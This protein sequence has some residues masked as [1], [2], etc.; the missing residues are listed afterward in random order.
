[1]AYSQ[2]TVLLGGLVHVPIIVAILRAWDEKSK[3][4]YLATQAI[5]EAAAQ[6][7]KAEAEAKALAEA[8]AAKKAK[9]KALAEAKAAAK[10]EEEK[11]VG[12]NAEQT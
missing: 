1:M 10:A 4:R 12:D 7:L 9:E 11:K 3:A 8:K 6:K 2:S 5:K